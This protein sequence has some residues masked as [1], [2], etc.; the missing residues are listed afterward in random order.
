MFEPLLPRALL[1]YRLT[2]GDI[3]CFALHALRPWHQR[4]RR[5]KS[6]RLF[7]CTAVLKGVWH[8]LSLSL[9]LPSV[10]GKLVV[11]RKASPSK[12]DYVIGDPRL[13]VPDPKSRFRFQKTALS[14]ASE[15]RAE[16]N[17][18]TSRT[19]I[20]RWTARSC[21]TTGTGWTELARARCTKARRLFGEGIAD[22]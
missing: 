17:G 18:R 9:A 22:E 16:R 20:G 19:G 13:Q 11:S 14:A 12:R 4:I 2:F 15:G 6:A 21:H 3:W 10:L 1:H 8:S 5:S 7:R